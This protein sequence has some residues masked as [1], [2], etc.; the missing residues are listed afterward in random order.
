[1][2]PKNILNI[3]SIKRGLTFYKY[4]CNDISSLMLSLF[5]HCLFIQF[6]ATEC[7]VVPCFS[8]PSFCLRHFL[9]FFHIFCLFISHIFFLK[10]DLFFFFFKFF[11]IFFFFYLCWYEGTV[12][13]LLSFSLLLLFMI[14]YFGPENLLE[15][16]TFFFFCI[17]SLSWKVLYHTTV[18]DKI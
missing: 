11:F 3:K 12:F 4:V 9:S 15:M 16:F 14:I 18:L 7:H 13:L 2:K 6:S 8:C 5:L 10:H 17:N 1:M